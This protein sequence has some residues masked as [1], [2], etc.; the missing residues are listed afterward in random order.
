VNMGESNRV[1]LAHNP[2]AR[3][4]LSHAPGT[5]RDARRA[6]PGAGALLQFPVFGSEFFTRSPAVNSGEYCSQDLEDNFPAPVYNRAVTPKFHCAL[7]S[8]SHPGRVLG[9]TGTDAR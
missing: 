7:W 9:F 6:A 3:S 5:G 1:R 2:V 8:Y 4:E